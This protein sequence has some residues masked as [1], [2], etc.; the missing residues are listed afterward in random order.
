[1]PAGVLILYPSCLY[2]TNLRN[3]LSRVAATVVHY[4][5]GRSASMENMGASATQNCAVYACY[6]EADATLAADTYN[7]TLWVVTATELRVI[8]PTQNF[9]V[10]GASYI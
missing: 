4:I 8:S 5:V 9:P 10:C 7:S 1:M 3:L 6:L 2:K